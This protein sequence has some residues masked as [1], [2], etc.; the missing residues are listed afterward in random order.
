MGY[1]YT[2]DGLSR[3]VAKETINPT[4]G[5]IERRATQTLYGTRTWTGTHTSPLLFAGQYEDAESGWAYNR[6]RYYN[7]TLGAYNAQ[8][9]L[10]LAPRLASAQGYVDHAAFWVDV[11]EL[12][13]HGLKNS[14]DPLQH[15]VNQLHETMSSNAQGRVTL[16]IGQGEDSA[17]R[18]HSVVA[19]SE[20]TRAD[21]TPY[22]RPEVRQALENQEFANLT[23]ATVEGS[24]RQH[25]EVNPPQALDRIGASKN[26]RIAASR[27]VCQSCQETVF[28]E[29]AVD[30]IVSSPTPFK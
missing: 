6:F 21:G 18:V 27:L 19:S 3:R 28:T 14:D 23:P 10:G 15:Q 30:R 16:A 7:P 24:V 22:F 29:N 11:R 5:A 1:R 4:T 9:P 25:A 26:Q 2:Y 8:D 20:R 13:A 17:G 12:M